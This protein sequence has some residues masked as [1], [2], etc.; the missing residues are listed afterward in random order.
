MRGYVCVAI[1]FILDVRVVDVPAG[2]TQ[3]EGHTGF[4]LLPSAA[5]TF[6]FIARRIHGKSYN[7]SSKVSGFQPFIIIG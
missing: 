6:I 7:V 5:F 4:L 1:P 2:I 3:E